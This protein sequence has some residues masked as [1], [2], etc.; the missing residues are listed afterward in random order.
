MGP[1]FDGTHLLD[2]LLR[3]LDQ[4][5]D[6]PLPGGA[7][8]RLI[9]RLTRGLPPGLRRALARPLLP[10]LRRRLARHPPAP[11]PEFLE[12]GERA[13][14]R[15]FLEPNNY[16]TGG[17]RLNLAGREPCGRVA[18][19]DAHRVADRLAADLRA[20]VNVD[21]GGPVIRGLERS[22]RWYRRRKDDTMPD[23]FLAWERSRPVER[24]WSPQVGLVSA[25]YAHWRS[26]DHR[27]HG[28]LVAAGPGVGSLPAALAIEDLGASLAARLGLPTGDMDG[29]PHPGLEAA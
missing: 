12:A 2:A 16:V 7:G 1:H 3:R 18:P 24:V 19:G 17:I 29:R 21:D 25:P 23:L 8:R 15:F 14:Q 9:D 27:P 26:G 22:D 5:A 10:A 11:V 28:L 4:A 6:G 13:G 20:L